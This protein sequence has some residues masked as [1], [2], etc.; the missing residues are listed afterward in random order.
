MSSITYYIYVLLCNIS[1]EPDCLTVYSI[2]TISYLGGNSVWMLFY[3]NMEISV[4]NDF[5]ER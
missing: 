3:E 1:S 2:P 5:A 4:L